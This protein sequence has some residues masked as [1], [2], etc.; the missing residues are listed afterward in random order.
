MIIDNFSRYIWAILLKNKSPQRKTNELS[1]FLTSKK[2]R[3]IKIELDRGV[4]FFDSIF[5]NSLKVKN[6]YHCSRFTG[7]RPSKAE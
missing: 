3:T 7:K 6:I 4:E 2:R 5:Q 1:N